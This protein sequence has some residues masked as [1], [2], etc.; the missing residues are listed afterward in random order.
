MKNLPCAWDFPEIDPSN[1]P[2]PEAKVATWNGFVFINQDPDGP[3]DGDLP[4]PRDSG[5]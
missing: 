4:L 5:I 3:V 1:F 2:L